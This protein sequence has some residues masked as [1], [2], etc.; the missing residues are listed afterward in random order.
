MTSTRFL[1]SLV[2]A[3]GVLES[4]PAELRGMSDGE[5]AEVTRLSSHL[6]RIAQARSAAVAGEVAFRSRPELG[7]SGLAQ[8][9][10]HRTPEAMVRAVTGSTAREA[11]TSVRVGRLV[12]T[13]PQRPWLDPVGA[14]VA[15]GTLTVS[16]AEAISAGLGV[17]APGV[18]ED[19]LAAVAATLATDAGDL[20]ADRLH[21]LAR[22]ARDD[23]DE[24]GIADREARRF[25]QRSLTVHRQSDGMVK[26]VWLLDP[27]SAATVLEIFDRAT[28]P[29]RGGPRFVSGANK[30]YADRIATDDRTTAQLASDTFLHLVEAAATVDDS[31]LLGSGGPVI[32]VLATVDALT[33]AGGHG[34]IEGQPDPIGSDTLERL[35]CTG[36]TTRVTI[37]DTGPLDVG[38]E[39]RRFTRKQRVA[40]AARD[41]GCM[42]PGCDRPAS[43]TEAH[44]IDHWKD[45]HG[46][47][48]INDGILL[49]T[50]DH[51]TL[52]NNTWKIVRHGTTYWLTPPPD[53]DPT[54]LPSNST[55]KAAPGP[56]PNGRSREKPRENSAWVPES[57]S[58]C[59]SSGSRRGHAGEV[60]QV[61]RAWVQPRR[62]GVR[63]RAPDLERQA[64][65]PHAP[66]VTG[67]CR[68]SRRLRS[69]GGPPRR[70]TLLRPR[71]RSRRSRS[72]SG[73]RSPRPAGYPRRPARRMWW[74]HLRTPR[75]DPDPSGS[76][77]CHCGRPQ[78]R[79]QPKWS[80]SRNR[81]PRSPRCR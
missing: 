10:G 41:G 39:Q 2:E 57:R 79:E 43:W 32:R 23:I 64:S 74:L 71:S 7:S 12:A 28:S 76:K 78:S 9:L 73:A 72:R 36:A 48:D 38:R 17:P 66:S 35:A 40:L 69:Q 15:D 50:F 55:A 60:E 18:P 45:D 68:P 51:L 75:S 44:H 25:A 61:G 16:G 27:E 19:V 26:L 29:R 1:D 49:C 81:C 52:H 22:E 24:A 59:L 5:F 58:A 80:R 8:R 65:S 77:R 20:D 11:F 54:K 34:F 13:D 53:I 30:D 21:R 70:R 42:W 62:I 3:I 67:S 14:A 6:L 4:A 37:T 46:A 56:K 63:P 31:E 47:T 33:R